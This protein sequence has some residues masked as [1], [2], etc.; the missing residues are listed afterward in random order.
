MFDAHTRVRPQPSGR[1]G[2]PVRDGGKAVRVHVRAQQD[3][4][5]P[6]VPM[7]F[8]DRPDTARECPRMAKAPPP[9]NP[10][11]SLSPCGLISAHESPLALHRCF[12]PP[13]QAVEAV[14]EAQT[15]AIYLCS[16]WI[17]CGSSGIL[18]RSKCVSEQQH[19]CVSDVVCL[20]RFRAPRHCQW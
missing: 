18:I 8:S 1:G 2:V 11:A 7:P 16:L 20:H 5:V 10:N 15:V 12:H 17:P 13:S 19:R 14:R 4:D 3:R 9:H 6:P